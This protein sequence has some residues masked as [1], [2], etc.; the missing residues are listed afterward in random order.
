MTGRS[1]SA[2]VGSVSY[3]VE[4]KYKQETSS[5]VELEQKKAG[6]LT[7]TATNVDKPKKHRG[8]RVGW[9]SS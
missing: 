3:C 8:D 5:V 9:R 2:A 7:A 4:P 6:M 1:L